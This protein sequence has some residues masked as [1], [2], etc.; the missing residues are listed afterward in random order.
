MPS[1]T[2]QYF[3]SISRTVWTF[4]HPAEW[5]SCLPWQIPV[6]LLY[7][8]LF[9]TVSIRAE[10]NFLPYPP[11]S[12]TCFLFVLLDYVSPPQLSI[13]THPDRPFPETYLSERYGVLTRYLR[14]LVQRWV[15]DT[16]LGTM[17][18]IEYCNGLGTGEGHRVIT[19]EFGKYLRQVVM[20]IKLCTGSKRGNRVERPS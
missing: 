14:I 15:A 10:P 3:L 19:F 9:N 18:G 5:P 11:S 20:Q 13:L 2:T 17:E 4:Q 12:L 1:P 8:S 7:N 6:H 16:N